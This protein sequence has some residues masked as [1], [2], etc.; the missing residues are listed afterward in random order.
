L[1]FAFLLIEPHYR[2][3]SLATPF[4]TCHKAY[5]NLIIPYPTGLIP[6]KY[7]RKM[8]FAGRKLHFPQTDFNH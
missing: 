3:I 5:P 1:I 7:L 2:I 8:G 4:R 6:D